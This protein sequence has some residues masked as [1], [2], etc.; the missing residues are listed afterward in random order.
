MKKTKVKEIRENKW[1]IEE[2]LVLKE[3]KMYVPKDED[4]R[5]EVIWL[6]HDILAAGHGER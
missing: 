6:H 2:K 3:E 1:K 5:A 4:L